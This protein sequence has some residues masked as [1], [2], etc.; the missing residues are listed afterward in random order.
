MYSIF[1]AERN[2]NSERDRKLT[3][4]AF[5]TGGGGRV[6]FT[7]LRLLS[8][9][10]YAFKLQTKAKKVKAASLTGRGGP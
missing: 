2:R 9:L 10:L 7:S 5:I 6:P 4:T 8:F 3:E 1:I